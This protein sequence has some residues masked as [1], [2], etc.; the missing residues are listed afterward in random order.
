MSLE[1]D[2]ILFAVSTRS[3]KGDM[4]PLIMSCKAGW[5]PYEFYER[6]PICDDC[7]VFAS[8]E[9]KQS[10]PHTG[11]IRQPHSNDKKKKTASLVAKILGLSDA[12]AQEN[13][14]IISTS[15]NKFFPSERIRELFTKENFTSFKDIKPQVIYV[16]ID[17]ADGGKCYLGGAAFAH[18]HDKHTLVS[19]FCTHKH[20]NLFYFIFLIKQDND[21]QL[22]RPNPGVPRLI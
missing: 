12:H 11:H 20:K 14:N 17:P 16:G 6:N 8:N 1:G 13:L 7:M 10:C 4:E 22:P 18:Y 2:S 15:F 5:G 19:F 9:Q 3:S 21:Q